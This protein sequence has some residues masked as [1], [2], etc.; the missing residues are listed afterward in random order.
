MRILNLLVL[1]MSLAV[2]GCTKQ[3]NESIG[4]SVPL[5]ENDVNVTEK[6]TPASIVVEDNSN[7]LSESEFEFGETSVTTVNTSQAAKK[8]LMDN[9][10]SVKLV[11]EVTIETA[12]DSN[13]EVDEQSTSIIT[14]VLNDQ[15]ND[16]DEHSPI[17]EETYSLDDE[18]AKN[19]VEL[20]NYS[21]YGDP[22]QPG[23]QIQLAIFGLVDQ[24]M[25]IVDANRQVLK[26]IIRNENSVVSGEAQKLVSQN[27]V[28][29]KELIGDLSNVTD[30]SD[31]TKLAIETLPDDVDS[32]VSLGVTLYPDYAQEVITAATLTGEISG[33]DAMLLAIAAGAD[34]SSIS[35]ATAATAAN[36]VIAATP[37]PLGAGIG[38]AGAGGGDSTAS[39]N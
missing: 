35:T 26:N 1:T 29:S 25:S 19:E 39:I 34:P 3:P 38:A 36:A 4:A 31:A 12:T 6:D 37:T 11:E 28:V 33:E 17:T 32:I 2:V 23:Y 7:E 27:F 16:V 18:Q 30:L 9:I 21:F 8:Q 24:G 22:S 13:E 5:K 15:S 20:S 10:T 14:K